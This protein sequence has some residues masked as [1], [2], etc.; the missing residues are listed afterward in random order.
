MFSKDA[1]DS[2]RVFMSIS[3]PPI[4]SALAIETLSQI[5]RISELGEAFFGSDDGGEHAATIVV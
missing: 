2:V 3:R 5:D 4:P 1:P